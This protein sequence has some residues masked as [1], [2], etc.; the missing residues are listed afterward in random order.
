MHVF[1][2]ER[3]RSL[4]DQS[5]RDLTFFFCDRFTLARWSNRSRISRKILKLIK[6]GPR[7]LNFQADYVFRV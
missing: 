6:S 4:N 7:Y 3:L 2:I 5:P 1:W